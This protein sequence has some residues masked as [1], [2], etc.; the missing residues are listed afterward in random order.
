[1]RFL[2]SLLLLPF[3]AGCS[4][5]KSDYDIVSMSLEHVGGV[6]V[7]QHKKGVVIFFDA[8]LFKF[9]SYTLDS[10][11]LVVCDAVAEALSKRLGKRYLYVEGHTD[12]LGRGEVND[13]LSMERATSISSCIARSG[14]SVDRIDVVGY[15]SLHPKCDNRTHSGRVCNRRVEIVVVRYKRVE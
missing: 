15:G 9:D 5:L 3:I 6:T 7:E 8:A 4:L 1:M 11:G 10:Q 2:T 14:Y 13:K 12:N